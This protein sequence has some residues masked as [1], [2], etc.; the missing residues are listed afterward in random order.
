MLTSSWLTW[1]TCGDLTGVL[2]RTRFSAGTSWWCLCRST[3]A[4][5][6]LWCVW[7]SW[8]WPSPWEC[9][10]SCECFPSWSCSCSCFWRRPRFPSNFSSPS[11]GSLPP[12]P[13]FSKI[14]V[15]K[16]VLSISARVGEELFCRTRE[17]SC[18]ASDANVTPWMSVSFS[19]R[20]CRVLVP[21]KTK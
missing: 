16:N 4:P 2:R 21:K 13:Y 9:G 7:P 6:L 17:Y 3:S 19:A 10:W 11:Y 8:E 15:T 14:L 1:C 20:I 18:V 5:V 12:F